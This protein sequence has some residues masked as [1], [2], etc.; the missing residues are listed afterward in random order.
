M[1]RLSIVLV[2]IILCFGINLSSAA[3]GLSKKDIDYLNEMKQRHL[4]P[5]KLKIE[6]V[7]PEQLKHIRKAIEDMESQYKL[8]QEEKYTIYPKTHDHKDRKGHRD[9][10]VRRD[11]LDRLIRSTWN[12][13]LQALS[14]NQIDRALGYFCDETRSNYRRM[15]SALSPDKCRQL[16]LDLQD[17]QLIREV[18]QIVEYDL[19]V[20]R[21]GSEYSYLLI[22]EK[23]TAGEWKIRSF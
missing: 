9:Q 5:D 22:F 8:R 19:R 15:L 10:T 2:A 14:A 7:T 3:S 20:M 18:G 1:N 12:G 13:M 16:A 23:A 11:Q 4:L 17:I 6:E 21:N